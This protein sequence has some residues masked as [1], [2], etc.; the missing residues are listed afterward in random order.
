MTT[1][2]INW[3][4]FTVNSR[5]T[6]LRNWKTSIFDLYSRP[7][8]TKIKIFNDWDKLINIYW[9]TWNS[10]TFTIYG[11]ILDENWQKHNVKITKGYNYLLD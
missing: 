6:P 8:Y 11:D 1:K 5:L 10:C 4:T 7:S 3:I 9:L 2:T